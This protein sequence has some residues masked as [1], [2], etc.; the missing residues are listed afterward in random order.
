MKKGLV[1]FVLI[2]AVAIITLFGYLIYKTWVVFGLWTL[3]W[4]GV[5]IQLHL[6]D[7]VI[8]IVSF[9]NMSLIPQGEIIVLELKK[10]IPEGEVNSKSN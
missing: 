8:E 9:K 10:V 4:T 2:F 6:L 5:V 1:I 7:G 3:V